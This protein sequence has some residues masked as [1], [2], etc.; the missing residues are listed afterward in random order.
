MRNLMKIN[1][2]FGDQ[3]ALVVNIASAADGAVSTLAGRRLRPRRPCVLDAGAHS[4]GAAQD[5]FR[6]VDSVSVP[7]SGAG[8]DGAPL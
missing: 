1:F 6:V 8:V 5:M 7:G 4:S 3:T 2:F